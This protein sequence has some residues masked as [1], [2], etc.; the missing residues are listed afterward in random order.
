MPSLAAHGIGS[1]QNNAITTKTNPWIAFW[2]AVIRFDRAKVTPSLAIRNT[3]GVVLPLIGGV[4]IGM[5]SGGLA[6]ATGALN[7]SYSDS[8]EPYR[9]RARRMIAAS[10]LVGLAVFAGAL[11]G[12]DRT[13]A[14]L[15]AGGAAFICGLLVAVSQTAA[16][17][18]V[19]TLVT[20]IV[21]S[22]VPQTPARAV[23]AGLLA[24]AG[25]LFQTGLALA[26]WPLRRY[27]PERRVLADLYLEL[28]KAAAMPAQ[29]LS[30]PPASAESTRAQN[31][32]ASLHQDHS[33]ESE[34]YLMLLSQAE[35]MRLAILTLERLRIRTEREMPNSLPSAL[36]GRYLEICAKLLRELGISLAAGTAAKPDS[37][38]LKELD[39]ISDTMREASALHSPIQ[40]AL[41][42]D[43]VRQMD[44]LAGQ[45]R[46]S[47]ELASFST[48]EGLEEFDRRES[49]RPWNL[50]LAGI[51]AVLRANLTL[52]STAFRHA[53]RLAVCV[54][55]ASA[56]ARGFGLNRPYWAPMTVAI[57][58]K[59]DFTATFSRGILRLIGTFAG[60]L[61]ATVLV[62]Y[63]PGSVGV[64]IALIAVWMFVLRWVG[65]AN[66]GLFVTAVTGLIVI[67]IS[68]AGAAPREL[69]AARAI[70]TVAGGAIALLAYLLWPTWERKQLPMALAQM[71]D[72]Y[73]HYFRGVRN[74]YSTP[75]SP[76]AAELDQYRLAG[77]LARSN[78]EASVD[79]VSA[80]PGASR[81]SVGPLQAI[82]ASS[83][84]LVHAMMALESGLTSSHP[85]PARKAFQPFAN[86]V[87]LTLY[88]LASALRGSPFTPDHLPDLREAHRALTHSEESLTDRYTLVN[89][90]TD[91]ITN[92]LNTLSGE[93]LRWLNSD[94]PPKPS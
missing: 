58:L 80:E 12:H 75:D 60:L 76:M 10:F 9:N 61:L 8:H 17:L 47:T 30:A 69:V 41:V 29:I 2:Q 52:D 37:G 22:A 14:A 13:L 74:V 67:L 62:H 63:L 19:I 3:I 56:A 85:V 31:A 27:V 15:T 79:R 57:V 6:I 4:L 45:L 53:V 7:V 83:H 51:F 24:I 55:F 87:E 66:Y 59:P 18:G 68:L 65:S 94:R 78:A 82:L 44:A 21:Y 36:I 43:T 42:A 1:S 48:P 35:R 92:S 34:R 88:L 20:L 71:L 73:R 40:A 81:A 38:L 91:R 72:S 32:L 16:D 64:Q 54:A 28:S 5:T 46:S 77:R 70:N 26:F 90:E 93:V 84:R 25:G 49:S 33:V 86:Q 50:R 89:V 23:Y 39:S 11:V